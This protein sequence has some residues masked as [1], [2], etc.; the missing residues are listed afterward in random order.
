FCNPF[1]YRAGAD[2]NWHEP[3][4]TG[5]A[6]CPLFQD[7]P[8]WRR[9]CGIGGPPGGEDN[10][11]VH[12]RVAQSPHPRGL[13]VPLGGGSRRSGSRTISATTWAFACDPRDGNQLTNDW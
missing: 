11:A 2:W 8:D 9:N 13:N 4:I 10:P 12:F 7:R 5:Y 1:G 6:P 3:R